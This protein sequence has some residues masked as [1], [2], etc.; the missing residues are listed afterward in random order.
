MFCRASVVDARSPNVVFFLVSE[1]AMH[2]MDS[3]KFN[4]FDES[5]FL[6]EG[7]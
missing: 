5:F 1:I 7:A 3:T 4:V 2:V 6:A